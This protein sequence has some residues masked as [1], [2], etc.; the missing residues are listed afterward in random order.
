MMKNV[1]FGMMVAL[2]LVTVFSLTGCASVTVS[3]VPPNARVYHKNS[4]KRIGTTPVKINLYANSKEVVVRKD[5]YFSKTV[6]LSTIDPKNIDVELQRR[7]KVLLLSRPSGAELYVE[8]IK[9][10]V[11]KTP[12]RIDYDKPHR[13]FEVRSLGYASQS[14][15]I[16]EDPEGNMVVEL[17]REPSLI[18]TSKPKG[19]DVFDTDGQKLGQTPMAIP[20]EEESILELRKV[21]YYPQQAK[22]GSETESP[23]VVELKREPI[24]IIHSEPE[25]AIVTYRGVALGKTPYRRLVEGDM[26][27]EISVDRYYTRKITISPDSPR[28]VK[29]KLEPKPY[30]TVQSSPANAELYRSGGVE[31]IGRTPIE[32]LVEDDTSLEMHK[33]GYAIKPFTLS[34]TSSSEVTV[35]LVQSVGGIEKTVL[36]DSK[37]SGAKVYRP[38]G[39]ELIGTTP[40]K[41]R[42]RYERTFELQ[43]KGYQTKIVTIAPDSSDNVVFAL[44]KD[45]SAGNV[46]ISDPLLNTPLSF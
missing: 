4:D 22:I 36:I 26:D 15:A 31:L 29:V 6:L 20:A 21:G 19:A 28:Q 16:P 34:A 46:A 1:L 42:V 3:S 30:I 13:K 7:T 27:L 23:F 37:P 25:D 45:G 18:L 17:V 12:Y 14:I 32:I 35:P 43:Y 11:G 8:G 10:K 39:A 9:E 24:V 41:Q 33:P 2:G 5:G 44:A 40:L 38:G